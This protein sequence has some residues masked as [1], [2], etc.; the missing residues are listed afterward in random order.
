MAG[1]SSG[2]PDS[3][4]Q[5]DGNA[6][7]QGSVNL[8]ELGASFVRLKSH[9]ICVLEENP[10]SYAFGV[11]DELAKALWKGVK[12]G[13]DAVLGILDAFEKALYGAADTTNAAGRTLTAANDGAADAVN[14]GRR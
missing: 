9:L 3:L 5:F 1:S 11:G 4:L 14:G 7:G 10:Y 2:G 6:A 8:G 12:P 13:M